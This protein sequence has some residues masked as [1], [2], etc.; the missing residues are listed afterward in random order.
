M[1][2]PHEQGPLTPPVDLFVIVHNQ[3]FDLKHLY[4][5]SAGSLDEDKLG[6]GL[7]LVLASKGRRQFVFLLSIHICSLF[8]GACGVEQQWCCSP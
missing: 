7:M 5:S 2:V 4:V 3:Y 8:G 6:Q 1:H